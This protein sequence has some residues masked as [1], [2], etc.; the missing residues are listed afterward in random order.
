[1]NAETA[2]TRDYDLS[3]YHRN[4]ERSNQD[5]TGRADANANYEKTVHPQMPPFFR[6]M[7]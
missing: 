6:D 2:T 1:M 7:K 5:G 3:T 4:Q